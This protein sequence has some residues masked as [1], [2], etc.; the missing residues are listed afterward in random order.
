MIKLAIDIEKRY[1]KFLLKDYSDGYCV[2]FCLKWLGDVLN[3]NKHGYVKGAFFVDVKD[4]AQ[5][6]NLMERAKK[7]HSSYEQNRLTY[8]PKIGRPEGYIEF[9]SKYNDYKQR[10]LEK[11]SGQSGLHYKYAELSNNNI[12]GLDRYPIASPAKQGVMM[13]LSFNS[14]G[15]RPQH[16][17]AAIRVTEEKCYFF[18]PNYGLY[19]IISTNPEFEIKGLLAQKYHDHRLLTQVVVSQSRLWSI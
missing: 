18:D 14:Q 10:E 19:E 4:K 9:V 5:L 8:S 1:E 7:K 2:G 16:A 17:V 13:S 3:K 11:S 6:L 12:T 15:V